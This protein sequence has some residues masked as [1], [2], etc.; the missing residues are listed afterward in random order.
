MKTADVPLLTEKIINDVLDKFIGEI[1]QEPPMFSALKVK[2]QPLYKY[3]RKG[4]DMPLEKVGRLAL[5]VRDLN[6]KRNQIKAEVVDAFSEGFKEIR[7]N[8]K[9]VDYGRKEIE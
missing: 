4:I 9:K 5:K 2:G 6:R 1:R 3:A 7:I 8:Y